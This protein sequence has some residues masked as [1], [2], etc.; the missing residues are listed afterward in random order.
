MTGHDLKL[1]DS[2]RKAIVE[3]FKKW[4]R[5]QPDPHQPIFGRASGAA[6]FPRTPFQIVEEIRRWTPW[7]EKFVRQW[8]A[9]DGIDHILNASV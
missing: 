6:S 4:L 5:T 8:I 9:D 3:K 1:G 2:D 7:A